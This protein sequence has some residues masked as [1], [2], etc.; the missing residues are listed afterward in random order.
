MKNIFGIFFDGKGLKKDNSLNIIRLFLAIL[1]VYEHTAPLGGY[2]V[3]L[4]L[5]G[6]SVG[7]WAVYIF[8]GISGYLITASAF[9]NSVPQYLIKR[10]A[11]IFP[12][13]LA[14][15]F[16]TAFIFAPLVTLFNGD[17]I[18]KLWET[19]VTPIGYFLGNSLLAIKSWGIGTTLST[20]PY[21]KA[22][23]GSTWTIWNEFLCYIIIVIIVSLIIKYKR[24]YVPIM[25]FLWLGLSFLSSHL[26]E[27][28]KLCGNSLIDVKLFVP[29]F[30]VF[31]AGS[32]LY[33]LRNYLRLNLFGGIVSLILAYLIIISFPNFGYQYAAPF[34]LFVVF[35]IANK[36]PSPKWIKK[37]DL[38]Y[39]VYLVAFPIQQLIA[40]A[41][42]KI[43]ISIPF[44]VFAVL[45][46]ILSIVVA[47][48]S[49]K[50][51]E[52]PS[53]NK[54]KGNNLTNQEKIDEVPAMPTETVEVTYRRSSRI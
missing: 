43:G 33:T 28:I 9:S 50:Y 8:F 27:V 6:K 38:S 5:F 23:N 7:A 44:I 46:S 13:Y 45:A 4:D 11:R 53:L 54:V 19:P 20:N 25:A 47:S 15:Q 22:W 39:G 1:V 34:I 2:K 18:A 26:L 32:L 10:I 41:L 31:M 30:A 24:F 36:I 12:A 51:V 3:N 21:P 14:I 37:N 35:V 42:L 29:L 17:S 48:L 52:L 16:V 40:F 49:W